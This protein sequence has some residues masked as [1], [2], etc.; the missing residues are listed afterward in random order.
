MLYGSEVWSPVSQQDYI[1][2]DKH[3]VETLHAE[4]CKNILQVEQKTPNHACRAELGCYP[5]LTSMQKRAL[6]FWMHRNRSEPDSL[7]YKAL[8]TQEL[9]PEKSLL[10]QLVLKLTTL[11]HTNTNQLQ[12]SSATALPIRVNR[13]VTQIKNSYLEHWDKETKTPNKLDCYRAL[14]RDFTLEGSPA[15]WLNSSAYTP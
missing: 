2:W 5:L 9:S 15:A 13:T 8:L 6:Q 3:P 14:K 10:S 1:K 11:T 7:Q 4:F 12:D